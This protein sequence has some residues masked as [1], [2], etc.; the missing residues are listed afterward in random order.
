MDK[1]IKAKNIYTDIGN[2]RSAYYKGS[3][4]PFEDFLFHIFIGETNPKLEFLYFVV[5]ILYPKLCN[6][7]AT[8][9]IVLLFAYLHYFRRNFYSNHKT[10]WENMV[11]FMVYARHLGPSPIDE[12]YTPNGH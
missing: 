5:F 1:R 3:I 11:D 8:K 2:Y 10:D 12:H 7:G 4:L 6:G 9:L